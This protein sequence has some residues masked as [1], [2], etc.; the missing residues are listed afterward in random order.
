MTIDVI[1]K[2]YYPPMCSQT[3]TYSNPAA[4]LSKRLPIIKTKPRR[5]IFLLS[6]ILS[7]VEFVLLFAGKSL[8]NIH[9]A[10]WRD[11]RKP[12]SVN[13]QMRFLAKSVSFAWNFEKAHH[14]TI[15][16]LLL[17]KACIFFGKPVKAASVA[18]FLVQSTTDYPLFVRWC[19]VANSAWGRTIGKLLLWHLHHF[20][21]WSMTGAWVRIVNKTLIPRQL[22]EEKAFSVGSVTSWVFATPTERRRSCK[23]YWILLNS[24]VDPFKFIFK[25]TILHLVYSTSSELIR[26]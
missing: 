3:L 4:D 13:E 5:R 19:P 24:H 16:S 11:L 15:W 26:Y 20:Y 8:L 1:F 10:T 23:C 12:K 14:D 2:E 22:W 25:K 17:W 7:S 21:A 6:E 9:C 18:G